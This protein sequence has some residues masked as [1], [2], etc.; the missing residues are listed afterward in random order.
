MNAKTIT[1]NMIETFAK[2]GEN[3]YSGGGGGSDQ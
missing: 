3:F 1:L 2:K